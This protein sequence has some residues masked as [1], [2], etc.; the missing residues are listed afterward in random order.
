MK[1][2]F[3]LRS[4]FLALAFIILINFAGLA[5]ADPFLIATGSFKGTSVYVQVMR[6]FIDRCGPATGLD[7][8]Q[9][10]STGSIVNIDALVGNQV[11]AAMVQSDLLFYTQAADE[12]KTANIKTVVAFYPEELHF[13]GTTAVMKQGGVSLGKFNIGGSKVT[14]DSVQNLAGATVGAVGGSVR[15]GELVSRR[16]GL[17][18]KVQQFADNAALQ[19]AL[20]DGAIDAAL[21]VGGAPHPLV[22]SLDSAR[23]RLLP[24]RLDSLTG[25]ARN[26]LLKLYSPAKISYNNF[27]GAAVETLSVQSLLVSRQYRDPDMLN[28]LAK[29][30]ACF[31]QQLPKIQDKTGTHPAWQKVDSANMGKW[32]VYDLP[33][34]K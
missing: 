7:L 2:R 20:T 34:A 30:R 25:D 31:V 12:N 21:V 14:Y 18:F 13:I 23:F 8:K 1:N 6:E 5:K 29:L 10:E 19:K 28:G 16:S 24:L 32:S 17:G 4:L 33:A 11:N 15:T 27:G 26:N 3:Y 9:V 22:A